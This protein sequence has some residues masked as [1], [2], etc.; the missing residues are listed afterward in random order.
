MPKD[1]LKI[2]LLTNSAA[3]SS[4]SAKEKL[5][6][7]LWMITYCLFFKFTPKHPFNRWRLFLLKLFGAKVEGRPF[8]F[9]SAQ[10]FA[11]WL[12]VLNDH[13]CLGPNSEV[14]NLGPVSIGKRSV[15]SQYAYICN[16][17][18]DFS[19]KTMPLLIG[20]IHVGDD[21][22]IGARAMILPGISL[23]DGS[24]VGAGAVVTKDVSPWVVVAGN[25]ARYIKNR[26]LYS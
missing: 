7:L 4:W 14:Y 9:S 10:V 24:L 18:H 2:K 23:G 12:L 11:P 8:V 19:L 13:C 26:E 5:L 17:T 21:V 6:R 1:N 15:L 16:G 22:F 3:R 25:P 20:D